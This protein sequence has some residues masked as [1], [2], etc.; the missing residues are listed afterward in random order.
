[1]HNFK[2][3]PELTNEQMNT[4]YFNSPHKQITQDFRAK[5][6]KVIDGDTVQIE[7]AERDFP[8]R[9][10]LR[11][12]DAPELNNKGGHE[13]KSHLQN[14]VEGKEVEILIDPKNRVEKWGRL[15]GDIMIRG[16]QI[17]EEMTR[18]GHAVPFDQ[19][20]E[21]MLPNIHKELRLNQWLTI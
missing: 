1:M 9:M 14:L 13:A 8:F 12:I 6:K 15:L 2:D 4:E 18:F 17:S 20:R 7:W 3:F 10:R 16:I 21:T 11:D 5:I 19:R